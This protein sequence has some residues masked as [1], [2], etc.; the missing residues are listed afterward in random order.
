MERIDIEECMG[1]SDRD[2]PSLI[3]CNSASAI[4]DFRQLRLAI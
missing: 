2:F 1:L 3:I 4:A